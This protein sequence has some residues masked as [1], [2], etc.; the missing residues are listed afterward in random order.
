MADLFLDPK[1]LNYSG[2]KYLL[3]VC[4]LRWARAMK[5]KGTPETM[6]VLI[7][8]AL[9]DLLDG[10]VTQEEVMSNQTAAPPAAAGEAAAVVVPPEEA[11]SAELRAAVQADDG[12]D[13]KKKAK[14]KK[15]KEA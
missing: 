13:E 7:E 5:A 10:K 6:P 3:I 1:V 4:V 9:R 14:K 11:I 8:K 2:D 15:K 12:E